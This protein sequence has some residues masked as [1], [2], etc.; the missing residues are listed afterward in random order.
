MEMKSKIKKIDINSSPVYIIAGG[1]FI[2]ILVLVLLF[3]L[4]TQNKQVLL[5]NQTVENTEHITGYVVKTESVVD[6]DLNK[7]L[8]PVVSDGA[9]IAKESIIATYKGEEYANYEQTL[10][11][12]DKEILELMQHLPT[13]YSSEVDAIDMEI[14]NLVKACTN[15][16]SYASMQE[17]K[18]KINNNIKKRAGII[19]DLSPKGA[20]IKK[21]IDERNNYELSAKKSTDNILAPIPGVVSYTTDGL[22]GL[23]KVS[24][25]D[26]LTY[27][28]IKET[29][30]N[31]K[32]ENSSEIKVVNNYEAYIVTKVKLEDKQYIKEGTNYTIRLV[33]DNGYTLKGYLKKVNETED[34][35][36]LFFLITNGVEELADLRDVEIEIVWWSRTGLTVST[37]ILKKYDNKEVYYINAIKYSEIVDIPVKI[38]KKTD[39]FAVI[40]NYSNEELEELGIDTDYKIKLYD[41]IIIK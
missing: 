37:D 13:V 27:T 5:K 23:L 1:V 39:K 8:I 12:M 7:I 24:D 15:E 31:N 36:E 19:G 32:T 18:Q 21:I 33:E 16:T 11:T 35:I 22:E 28:S 9:R 6:K 26:N 3:T 29:V 10:N 2:A 41:R 30:K 17:Y 34:G 14:Y 25:I 38:V 4:G 40:T 20:E